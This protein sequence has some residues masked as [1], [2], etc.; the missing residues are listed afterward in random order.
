MK[1]K[2]M[3]ENNMKMILKKKMMQMKIMWKGGLNGLQR[4]KLPPGR[5]WPYI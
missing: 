4:P 1:K 5:A 3:K 2:I